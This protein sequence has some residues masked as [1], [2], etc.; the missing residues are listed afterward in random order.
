VFILVLARC[1]FLF[2]LI[3]LYSLYLEY[4]SPFLPSLGASLVSDVD[5]LSLPH[6]AFQTDIISIVPRN[7]VISFGIALRLQGRYLSLVA[8]LH[9]YLW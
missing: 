2:V 6:A 7:V 9:I 8:L 3:I 1:L 4:D 5:V